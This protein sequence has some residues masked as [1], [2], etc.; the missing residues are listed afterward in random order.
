MPNKSPIFD[1]NLCMACG[2]CEQ[3]CPAG[4]LGMNKNGLDKYK[5]VY[6]ALETVQDCIGCGICQKVCPVEAIQMQEM[7]EPLRA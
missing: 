7:A 3:A 1:Y 2:V 4:C 6:P 5:K